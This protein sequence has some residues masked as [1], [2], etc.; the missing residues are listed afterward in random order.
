MIPTETCL[1]LFTKYEIKNSSYKIEKESKGNSSY[2]D[3]EMIL[4]KFTWI[5]PLIAG[6]LPH[7]HC[8]LSKIGW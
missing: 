3:S 1:R 7:S 8:Y 5:A 6:A 4:E 2:L